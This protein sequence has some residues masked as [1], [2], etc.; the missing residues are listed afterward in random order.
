MKDLVEAVEKLESWNDGTALI[1]SGSAG[2]FCA[3]LD[4]SL[5]RAEISTPESG[6]MMAELMGG[7][8][9][10]LRQLPLLSV[11]AIDGAAIG[12]GAEL[13]TTCDWRVMSS[14]SKLR[15]V[16]ASM[17]V[18]TGWGGAARLV[19]ICGRREALKLLAHCSPLDAQAATRIG[20]CDGIAA[21]DECAADAALRLLIEPA[22]S[23][24]A[25]RDALRAVKTVVA[26]TS[27]IDEAVRRAEMDA[28][29]SVWGV[30]ANKQK[31][32]EI[33]AKM[34]MAAGS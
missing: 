5:S 33:V 31:F 25:S 24:A 4:F 2:H 16:Q 18:S 14:K 15:F 9:H 26:A 34:E 11:A 7:L 1:I 30:G 27:D 6:H 3:G 29:A 23:A 19:N 10:R 20:L 22:H 13:A 17:G 12:G 8:L 32:D 28:V 21:E